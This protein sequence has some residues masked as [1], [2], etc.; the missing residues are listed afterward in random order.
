VEEAVEATRCY[1]G[2]ND[3]ERQ[4]VFNET[5]I[6]KIKARFSQG[7]QYNYFPLLE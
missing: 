2:R 3:E 5:L 4:K 6:G 7:M 1:F